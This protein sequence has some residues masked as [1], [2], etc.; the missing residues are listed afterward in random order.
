MDSCLDNK[1]ISN[2]FRWMW[3]VSRKDM[4]EKRQKCRGTERCVQLPIGEWCRALP[5]WLIDWFIGY[6]W[7]P[8]WRQW[9]G[10]LPTLMAPA[11]FW[12]VHVVCEKKKRRNY[13][14]YSKY[15]SQCNDCY[16]ESDSDMWSL[17]RCLWINW[18]TVL[19][20]SVII[21]WQFLLRDGSTCSNSFLFWM[22]QI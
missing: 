16:R 10:S 11:I 15:W 8:S 2:A 6:L 9:N 4:G 20:T 14:N 5:K 13:Y 7:A 17:S 19:G 21:P 18:K 1:F 3:I 22:V 12:H